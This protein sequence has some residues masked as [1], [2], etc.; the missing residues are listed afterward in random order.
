MTLDSSEEGEGK[1]EGETE[2]ERR[3]REGG[4][5]EE[6][7]EGEIESKMDGLCFVFCPS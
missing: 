6:G 2:R 4:D 1:K 5:G 3:E 7:E